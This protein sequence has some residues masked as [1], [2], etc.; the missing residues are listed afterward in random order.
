VDKEKEEKIQNHER[1]KLTEINVLRNQKLTFADCNDHR[2]IRRF[3]ASNKRTLPDMIE[4]EVI[5]FAEEHKYFEMYEW[6]INIYENPNE[7]ED[8]A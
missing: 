3:C 4:V 2:T 6:H 1:I 7:K 8:V 5:P